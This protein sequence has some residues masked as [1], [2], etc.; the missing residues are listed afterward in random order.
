MLQTPYREEG[1]LKSL[2]SRLHITLEAHAVNPHAP[3][4]VP[5]QNGQM[6]PP[7]VRA[8]ELL[9]SRKVDDGQDPF[10]MLSH[11]PQDEG[12][13]KSGHLIVAWKMSLFL[14][15]NQI[16]APKRWTFG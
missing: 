2:L 15:E 5:A 13:G 11:D 8:R 3:T 16:V 6:Q 12:I 7:P 9:V 10:V 4:Q 1:E 14:G